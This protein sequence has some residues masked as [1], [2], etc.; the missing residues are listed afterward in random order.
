[1]RIIA[2]KFKGKKLFLP[3]DKNTRPLKDLVKE[4]I[5][6]LLEHSA[7][8][9]KKIEDASVLDLFSGSGSFGLECIS[10]G[11]QDVYFFE[12]YSLAI[13]TL[14]RNILL[15]DQNNNSKVFE[16]DC[17]NYFNSKN[18][19][20]KSFDIIFVDPPYKEIKINKLI[21]NIIEKKILNKRGIII[22]HRHKKDKLEITKKIKI[23]DIR[24][25][26]ISKV[27]FGN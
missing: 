6:N 19:L 27:Y 26:G 9:K 14:K 16:E 4:S 8:I 5:F 18:I 13:R 3:K 11:S 24:N 10:R 1:M 22:I 21:E 23:L 17:F 20:N 25:Y 2:G 7:Q 15:F 12:N